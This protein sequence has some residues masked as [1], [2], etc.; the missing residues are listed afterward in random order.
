MLDRE[1]DMGGLKAVLQK[2]NRKR[3]RSLSGGSLH[4]FHNISLLEFSV[5]IGIM[6]VLVGMALPVWS[7]I[8][9]NAYTARAQQ[10]YEQA[11][12]AVQR[13]WVAQGQKEGDYRHFTA[14]YMDHFEFGTYWIE[15]NIPSLEEMDLDQVPRDYF[16]SILILKDSET[17]ADE[18]LIATI[19][20]NG[21]LFYTHFK[22]A[23][24]V[25][26]GKLSFSDFKSGK[27]EHLQASMAAGLGSE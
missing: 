24:I 15:V 6:G 19:S 1:I 26:S 11:E 12:A 23:N 17:A 18:A 27:G 14:Q 8:R 13:Y 5:V 25:E 20:E 22:K 16:A 9:N 2:R 7:N 10:N 4:P 3:D 21:K